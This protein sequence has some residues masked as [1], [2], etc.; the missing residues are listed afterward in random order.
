MC[1]IYSGYLVLFANFYVQAY[2]GGLPEFCVR[3]VQPWLPD[4]AVRLA[5]RAYLAHSLSAC[6][7][8]ITPTRSCAS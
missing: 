2:E 6:A 7:G 1:A 4:A 5:V 8:S 3:R